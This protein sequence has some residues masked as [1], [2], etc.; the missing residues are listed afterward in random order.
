MGNSSCHSILIPLPLLIDKCGEPSTLKPVPIN[1][2]TKPDSA[3]SIV[4]KLQ[5]RGG[6]NFGVQK[7]GAPVPLREEGLPHIEIL[8]KFPVQADVVEATG[9]SPC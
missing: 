9:D 3:G 4:Q 1:V 5:V 7:E 6:G 2:A 8:K